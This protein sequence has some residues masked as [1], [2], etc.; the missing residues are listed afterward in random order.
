MDQLVSVD[1]VDP[2]DFQSSAF[3]KKLTEDSYTKSNTG[4]QIFTTERL[5]SSPHVLFLFFFHQIF[6]FLFVLL[7]VVS[8]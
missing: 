2:S 3:P 1:D 8:L 4:K 6:T 7:S 5:L